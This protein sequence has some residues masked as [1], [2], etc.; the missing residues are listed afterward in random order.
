MISGS[1]GG[2]LNFKGQGQNKITNKT[3]KIC[4]KT[5]KKGKGVITVKMNAKNYEI[6]YKYDGI[7]FIKKK[8]NQS[9]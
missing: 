9:W 2:S 3:D 1:L 7:K 4:Y 5:N 6:K 8:D